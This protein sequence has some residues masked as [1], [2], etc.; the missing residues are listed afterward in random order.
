MDRETKTALVV[1]L[2]L[3]LL[4]LGATIWIIVASHVPLPGFGPKPDAGAIAH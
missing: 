4:A 1:L 3:G 2:P